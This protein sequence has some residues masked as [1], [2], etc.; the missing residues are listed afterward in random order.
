MGNKDIKKASDV[1]KQI[2]K[3]G[4]KKPINIIL[5]RGSKLIRLKVKPTDISNLQN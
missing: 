4:I 3:N 5:K 1:I 2:S